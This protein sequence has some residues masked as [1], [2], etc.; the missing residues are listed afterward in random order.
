MQ[1][2]D[3]ARH[4]GVMRFMRVDSEFA[5]LLIAIG[6]VILGLVGLPI[7]KWFLLGALMLGVAVALL[8]R[9]TRNS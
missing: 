3:P 7:A 6:F 8:L 4:P 5:S 1:H 9:W 2:R